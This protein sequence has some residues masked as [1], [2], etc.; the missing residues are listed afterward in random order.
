MDTSSKY[1]SSVIVS[2]ESS[3]R[4]PGLLPG[5]YGVLVYGK[6][7]ENEITLAY[8][9]SFYT[10]VNVRMETTSI[11]GDVRTETTGAEYPVELHESSNFTEGTFRIKL[12]ALYYGYSI[13]TKSHVIF[14]IIRV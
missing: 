5:T 14:S 10:S 13:R 6:E 9:Q 2:S 12:S 11:E 7:G 8:S 4:F 3:T 1:S